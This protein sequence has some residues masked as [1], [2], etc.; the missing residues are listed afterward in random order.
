MGI[1]NFRNIPLIVKLAKEYSVLMPPPIPSVGFGAFPDGFRI[2][3]QIT[4][5]SNDT[6]LT[7]LLIA[8]LHTLS[9]QA[10]NGPC[11]ISSSLVQITFMGAPTCDERSAASS[12]TSVIDLLPKAPPMN[13]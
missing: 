7:S 1:Y 4:L 5:C 3:W 10:L 12:T 6:S 2:S 9:E 8:P 13:V 11:D